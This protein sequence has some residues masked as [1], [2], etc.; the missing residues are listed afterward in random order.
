MSE[1]RKVTTEEAMKEAV[2]ALATRVKHQRRELKRL[3]EKNQ[4]NFAFSV[5]MMSENDELRRASTSLPTT[6]QQRVQPWLH[7][8]FGVEISSD[9]IEHNHHFLEEALELVQSTGCTASEAHQLVDYVFGRPVGE[10]NQESGGVSVTHAALCLAAGL[11]MHAAAETELARIWTKIEAIRAKQATKPKHSPLPGHAS[12][13]PAALGVE[14]VARENP[15][16]LAKTVREVKAQVVRAFE[17]KSASTKRDLNEAAHKLEFVAKAVEAFALPQPS[18]EVAA[19]PSV[20][21]VREA[22]NELVRYSMGSTKGYDELLLQMQL[23]GIRDRAR[24]VV[25]SFASEATPV[26]GKAEAE[27]WCRMM[28]QAIDALD[29]IAGWDDAR[30]G[31]LQTWAESAAGTIRQLYKQPRA[32]P[33]VPVNVAKLAIEALRKSADAFKV[34]QTLDSHGASDQTYI[35]WLR[36]CAREAELQA[37]EILAAIRAKETT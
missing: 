4:E 16:V 10:P 32:T 7:A 6:F 36:S 31:E 23:A 24:A 18:P 30:P 11:D 14:E 15:H 28:G 8:C 27:F 25:A 21:G 2:S 5:R 19:A 13:P 12:P 33:P 29:E 37:R 9:I 3:H 26:A 1:S 20:S 22:V 17:G 35:N 34:I